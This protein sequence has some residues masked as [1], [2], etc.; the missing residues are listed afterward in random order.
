[1]DIQLNKGNA[2]S[3]SFTD[4]LVNLGQPEKSRFSPEGLDFP[5]EEKKSLLD[6][7]LKEI[8]SLPDGTID[9]NM[10]SNGYIFR[11]HKQDS[12]TGEFHALRLVKEV[13]PLSELKMPAS[14]FKTL[15]D[16]S[17]CEGGLILVSGMTGSGK[18]TTL[19]SLLVERL[20]LF[21]GTAITIENPVEA[22]LSG[23]HGGGFC[24]QTS[25]TTEEQT[26]EAL[27][28]ALR[29]F[30]SKELQGILMIGEIR[31]GYTAVQALNAALSGHLVI[32]T[33][34]GK[35]II[36]TLR[37]M[38]TMSSNI[39]SEDEAHTVLA[40]TMRIVIHQRY[41]NGIHK[42]SMLANSA[43]TSAIRQHIS[44]GSLEKLSTP[45]QQQANKSISGELLW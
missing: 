18:S 11:G 37:R 16:K 34:H 41:E 22:M 31:D 30:P 43:E 10:T 29:C 3:K 42:F 14:L 32:A 20:N 9:Y 33:L 15:T 27:R 8:Q 17:L 44:N 5:T 4:I 25:V 24:I 26:H 35:D 19:S 13:L 21:G 40:D 38:V 45:I 23:E 2:V 28:G 7:L 36:A 6:G 39:I 1:M 12:I